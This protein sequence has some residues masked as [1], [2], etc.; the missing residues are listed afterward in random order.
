V[1][2]GDPACRPIHR[3]SEHFSGWFPRQHKRDRCH[4]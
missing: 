4:G 1:V 2:R 3:S